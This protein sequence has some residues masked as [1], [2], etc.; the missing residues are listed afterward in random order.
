MR[1]LPVAFGPEA[2]AQLRNIEHY[3]A[4]QG[5]PD[6][7]RRFVEAIVARC[8][9]IGG[10]P[11]GGTSRDDLIE[12]ARTIPF[13]RNTTIVYTVEDDAVVIAAVFYGGRDIDAYHS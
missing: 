5:R 11:Y 1:T 10:V 9:K 2:D 3:I 8:L 6:E 4:T 13:R 7:G 12:G